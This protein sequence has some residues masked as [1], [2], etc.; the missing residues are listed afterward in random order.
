VLACT[1]K[2]ASSYK[3]KSPSLMDFYRME[4]YLITIKDNGTAGL[5]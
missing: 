2:Y 5:A 4:F 1:H 3:N